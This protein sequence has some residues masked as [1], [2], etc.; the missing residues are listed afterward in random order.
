MQVPN[1]TGP[2][3]Y[4]TEP[5]TELKNYINSLALHAMPECFSAPPTSACEIISFSLPPLA[6]DRKSIIHR[7]THSRN[8]FRIFRFSSRTLFLRQEFSTRS[9][10]PCLFF[11][12]PPPSTLFDFPPLAS[13]LSLFSETSEDSISHLGKISSSDSK[14]AP[15]H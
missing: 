6:A 9:R 5:E 15:R 1:V 8:S 12:L 2:K 11:S 14:P 4:R 3:I 13:F 10:Q 7:P